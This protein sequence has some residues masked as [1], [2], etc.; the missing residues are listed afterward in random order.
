MS[1]EV[2]DNVTLL[3]DNAWATLEEALDN[4]AKPSEGLKS[5]MDENSAEVF[6][7][8]LKKAIE[9]ANKYETIDDLPAQVKKALPEAAQKMFLAVLIK[10]TKSD[11]DEGEGDNFAMAWGA[12]KKHYHKDENGKW[13]KIA[14]EEVASESSPLFFIR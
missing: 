13:V 7:E 2:S 6:H 14:D 3:D 5:L 11:D 9:D 10:A 4:P 1:N 8:T 12:V